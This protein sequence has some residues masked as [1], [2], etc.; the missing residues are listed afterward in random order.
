[1]LADDVTLGSKTRQE[2]EKRLE[3][4]RTVFGRKRHEDQQKED[5]CL[6]AGREDAQEKSIELQNVEIS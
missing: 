2:S 3:A 4:W 5:K 1:M 6:Y